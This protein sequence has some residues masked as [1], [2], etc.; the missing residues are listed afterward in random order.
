MMIKRTLVLG[1]VLMT[2][3]CGYQLRGAID[4]PEQMR[5]IYLKNASN[6]LQQQFTKTLKASS[7]DV[8]KQ[9]NQAGLVVAVFNEKMDRRVLSL[10]STGKASEFELNYS[11]DYELQDASGNVLKKPQSIEITREYYNDQEAIIAKTNEEVII[12]QEL[13][14]QAVKTIVNTARSDLTG[15]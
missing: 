12:Q 9:I 14:Q 4:L 13:Y 10:S 5:K 8:V 6:S 7:V 11:L 1:L 3:A 15:K 2:A